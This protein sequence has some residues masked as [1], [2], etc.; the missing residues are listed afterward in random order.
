MGVLQTYWKQVMA[1]TLVLM[2][3]EVY[4]A[5][6]FPEYA[7]YPVRLQTS[8]FLLQDEK[9]WVFDS[10]LGKRV[11][12]DHLFWR[13]GAVRPMPTYREALEL[14]RLARVP[15]V[16]APQV[17]LRIANRLAMLAELR[18]LDLPVIPFTA[19]VGAS[20]MEGLSPQLP[21]VIKIG[22]YHAGYGKMRLSTQEQWQDM[23]GMVMATDDYFTLEPFIDYKRDIRCLGVGNDVWAIARN[24]SHWKVNVAYA[25]TQL[26]TPPPTL[27][28][29][30]RR[31]MQH[32]KADILA[33]D[34]LE[35]QSGDYI[36][37]ECNSVP[38]LEGFPDAVTNAVVRE[39]KLRFN[40]HP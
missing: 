23:Q 27:A 18:E 10:A 17:M 24:G 20:L 36:V 40:I 37:L 32:F 12:V 22:S 7:V 5:D 31:T 6:Y 39:L 1:H 21:S 26:I 4:W 3:A 29:Y 14:V 15:C 9:L 33:L 13:I 34:I 38:G 2:N 25:E 30:T 28:E 8:R 16:N 35:T 11:R 19:A